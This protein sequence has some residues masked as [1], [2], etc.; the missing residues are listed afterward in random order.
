MGRKRPLPRPHKQAGS[1]DRH[2]APP[3]SL[4]R[5]RQKVEVPSP[6]RATLTT[7]CPALSEHPQAHRLRMGR[8]LR[9]GQL[10]PADIGSSLPRLSAP[11]ATVDRPPPAPGQLHTRARGQAPGRLWGPDAGHPGARSP[12]SPAHREPGLP[13]PQLPWAAGTARVSAALREHPSPL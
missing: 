9:S 2:G 4:K 11:G 6:S 1:S 12:L 3:R 13:G 7:G 5:N 10:C 8:R